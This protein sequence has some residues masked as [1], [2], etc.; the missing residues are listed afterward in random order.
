MLGS[1]HQTRAVYRVFAKS[2]SEEDGLK[3][4]DLPVRLYGTVLA[5]LMSVLVDNIIRY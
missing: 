3:V 2:G 4:S 1:G 5:D